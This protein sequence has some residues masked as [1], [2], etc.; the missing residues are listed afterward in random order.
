MGFIEIGRYWIN[1]SR[2]QYITFHRF[3][4]VYHI[5]FGKDS[6]FSNNY[7]IFTRQEMEKS[8]DI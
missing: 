4:K 5:Q 7:L 2:I 6:F 1:P 3:S 8:K